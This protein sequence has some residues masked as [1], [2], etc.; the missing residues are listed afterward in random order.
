MHERTRRRKI[1]ELRHNLIYQYGDPK[2]HEFYKRVMIWIRAHNLLHADFF[3]DYALTL[4]K[5]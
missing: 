4:M 1:A 5:K 3:G 2:C